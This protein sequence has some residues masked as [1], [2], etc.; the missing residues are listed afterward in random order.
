MKMFCKRMMFIV[1]L[2]LIV[3]VLTYII[4]GLTD[5]FS[6][7]TFNISLIVTG[8]TMWLSGFFLCVNKIWED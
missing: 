4:F 1:I 5:E 7:N 6:V 3:G 2:S 8:A